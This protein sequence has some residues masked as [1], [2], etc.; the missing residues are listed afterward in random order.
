MRQR[1]ALGLALAAVLAGAAAES[2]L[3]QTADWRALARATAAPWVEI[4]RPT[5]NL[6]DYLDGFN[7]PFEGTRYGDAMMGWALIQTGLR[8]GDQSMTDAGV[9]AIGYATS[10]ARHWARPS[11]FETMAVASAWN[12][13]R[14]PLARDP[15]FRAI[16]AQWMDWLKRVKTV[17]LRYVNRYGNHW[18]VDAIVVFELER[19][20]LKSNK[21]GAI[22]GSGAT[23][24]RRQAIRLINIRV[25]RMLSGSGPF[26]LSDPP[27]QPIAYHGLSLAFYARALR[28]MGNRAKPIARATLRRAVRAS[29]VLASPDGSVSYF[30]RSQEEIWTLPATAYAA[31]AATALPGSAAGFVAASHALAERAVRKLDR[32]YPIGA[33]GS[34][35]T[36][37]MAG[38]LRRAARGVDAY[39]GAPAY[40]GLEL[41]ML[42]LAIDEAAA[43]APA[44]GELPAD[45]LLAATVSEQHGRFAVV[46]RT[47]VWF[48]VKMTRSTDPHFVDDLRYD[49]GLVNLKRLVDGNWRDVVPERPRTSGPGPRSAAPV[50][51]TRDGPGYPFCTRISAHSDG[52]VHITGSFRTAAGHVIRHVTFGY[53]PR[54]CGVALRFHARAGEVFGLS[55]LFR[56]HVTPAIDG[57]AARSGGQ[58]VLV[59]PQPA[60]GAPSDI[61][62]S[63][64]D[65]RVTALPML[66]RA[67]T[68][69]TVSIRF[70]YSPR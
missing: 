60:F 62:A 51:L 53:F 47:D 15:E 9:R 24:A 50:L 42:N 61:G 17:R 25:P 52:S 13:A 6:P 40:D 63:G 33:R 44:E 41:A 14:G 48:A 36:P 38:D 3:A 37:A 67:K 46:R 64:N 1:I 58:E 43:A 54:A 34:W 59:D 20:G 68:D 49:F 22:L 19:S 45:H 30:D 57:G 29:Q 23:T 4:Q 2:A 12:I 5:G 55:P 21:P 31:E 70:C 16:R 7:N 39:A 26:V 35:I 65:A 28:L 8:E 18:L 27:D 11:V 69:R 56:G 66:L 32:D 10:K